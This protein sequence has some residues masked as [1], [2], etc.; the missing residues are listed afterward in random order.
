[1][2]QSLALLSLLQNTPH[3]LANAP[4]MVGWFERAVA[5]AV[6]LS[7]QRAEASDAVDQIMRLVHSTP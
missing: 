7:G 1:M 6:C 5:G 4:E 2:P 3:T